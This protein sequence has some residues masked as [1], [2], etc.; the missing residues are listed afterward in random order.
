MEHGFA[1]QLESLDIAA[2]HDGV[3]RGLPE[4][5]IVFAA[6]IS[7]GQRAGLLG[8]ALHRFRPSSGFPCVV[9]A[10][11]RPSVEGVL[12]QFAGL[13]FVALAIALEE[14]GGRDIQ[15]LYA[16]TERPDD[17]SLWR[18]HDAGVHAVQLAEIRPD[19]SEWSTPQRAELFVD[20]RDGSSMCRSDEWIGCAAWAVPL[21]ARRDATFRAHFRA[22]DGRNDWTAAFHFLQS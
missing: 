18:Q 17:I 15:Q 6:Y 20:R 7:N 8:R 12:R 9:P 22:A 21:V 1:L 2:G 16:A 11:P 10:E 19:A 14:D 13:H 5:A 3:L 4:P